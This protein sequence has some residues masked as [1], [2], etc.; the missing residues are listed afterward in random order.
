MA[1]TNILIVDDHP[2]MRRGLREL[3]A[4]ESDLVVCGE[5][6]DFNDAL[7]LVREKKPHMVLIDVS[8]PSGN[9]LE[10]AKRIQSVDGGIRMLFISM[11]DDAVFAMRALRAGALG[12]IN[13]SRPA[14]EIVEAVRKVVRG[15]IAVSNEMTTQLLRQGAR[16]TPL[17]TGEIENLSD[18]E[19]EVFE[20]IGRGLSTREIAEKL[21]LSVKTIETYREHLKKKL[22]LESGTELNHRAT[23][24]A[25]KGM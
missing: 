21:C 9:G 8:L 19:L 5:A 2:M 6:E 20:L 22:E 17:P 12:Y 25:S 11:H 7:E 3:I 13:K 16:L 23:L 4:A 1:Q 24:W 14:G 15:E 18:R 10:L